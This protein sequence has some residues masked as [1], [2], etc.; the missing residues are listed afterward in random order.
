MGW[1]GPVVD[2]VKA[3][4]TWLGETDEDEDTDW[5]KTLPSPGLLDSDTGD[6][7][8]ESWVDDEVNRPDSDTI[9]D[10]TVAVTVPP[11]PVKLTGEWMAVI[12]FSLLVFGGLYFLRP[13]PNQPAQAP[14]VTAQQRA[15]ELLT[16][17]ADQAAIGHFEV[18]AL[19]ASTA[20]M[21]LRE[22]NVEERTFK[23]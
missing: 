14:V 6:S 17:A 13:N 23:K 11:P 4:G 20:L 1:N 2:P 5:G 12:L 7:L 10:A 22:A 15:S 19:Q 18:A 21:V 9:D 16:E 3:T 8:D